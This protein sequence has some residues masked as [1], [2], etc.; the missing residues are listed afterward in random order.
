M[1]IVHQHYFF[2]KIKCEKDGVLDRMVHPGFM[3]I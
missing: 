1:V 3:E 2:E